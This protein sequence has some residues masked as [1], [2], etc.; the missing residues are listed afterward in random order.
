MLDS[1]AYVPYVGSGLLY[2]AVPTAFLCAG[3]VAPSML[4]LLLLSSLSQDEIDEVV[5]EDDLLE[6]EAELAPPPLLLLWLEVFRS[7]SAL[8]RP[9][10]SNDSR[11]LGIQG[12]EDV[13][14]LGFSGVNW[15]TTSVPGVV[16]VEVEEGTAYF[17]CK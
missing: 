4:K 3:D 16:V 6:Q 13:V 11:L 12:A 17:C 7:K 14:I 15:S 2:A 1:L 5:F 8:L 10:E 9:K